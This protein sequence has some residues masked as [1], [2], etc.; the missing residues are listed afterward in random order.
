ML[1]ID[2]A[3]SLAECWEGAY[4]DEAIATIVQEMENNREDTIVVFA[5]YPDKMKALFDRNPGLRSR[6]PFSVRFD[7]YSANEMLEI[8]ELEAKR[9]GFGIESEAAEK[10]MAICGTA[11][12]DSEGGNGR[13]C[14]NLVEGAILEYAFR[15]YDGTKEPVGVD[16][17]LRAEDFLI[18]RNVKKGYKAQ[19]IGF[20][21]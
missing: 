2:E 9:R 8:V 12:G 11:A 20:A 19:P 7:D 13:F 5:G 14:R 6:V 16:F 18:P 4:G 17:L 3:Y 1:F 10:V 21:V 15:N